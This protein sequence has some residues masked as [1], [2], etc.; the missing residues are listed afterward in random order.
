[1]I[2][3]LVIA[4]ALLLSN[5]C[6]PGSIAE[7]RQKSEDSESI[8][9]RDGHV[10]TPKSVLGMGLAIFEK[11]YHGIYREPPSYYYEVASK[12]NARRVQALPTGYRQRVTRLHHAVEQLDK[13]TGDLLYDLVGGGTAIFFDGLQLAATREEGFR[14]L[15]IT[16]SYRR[17]GNAETRATFSV[18][19]A[20]LRDRSR[21]LA[22]LPNAHRPD[23]PPVHRSQ[24]SS[25]ILALR[26]TTTEVER[27]NSALPGGTS[28]WTAS[29]LA[30]VSRLLK[31]WSRDPSLTK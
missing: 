14:D 15:L 18:Q 7:T 2:H 10:F 29:R 8:A 28:A 27:T 21:S 19:L 26:N 13:A 17:S 23:D 6:K 3:L 24:F 31:K 22:R 9:D 5:P 1:M 11:R 30:V 4:L 25:H 20:R 16:R 12:D